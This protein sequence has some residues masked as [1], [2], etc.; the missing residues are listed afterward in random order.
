MNLP[1]RL[2]LVAWAAFVL[3]IA[4]LASVSAQTSAPQ[5]PTVQDVVAPLPAVQDSSTR[6]SSVSP[7]TTAVNPRALAGG[8][9]LIVTGLL[10]LLYFYRRRVYILYWIAGWILTA[11]SMFLAAPAYQRPAVAHVAFGVS[12]FIAIISALMFVVSADAYRS[13]P[14]LRRE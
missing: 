10:L 3:V 4:P 5:I 14:R 6:T 12:Q 1:A 9:A 8:A 7:T 2:A 11:L 13:K